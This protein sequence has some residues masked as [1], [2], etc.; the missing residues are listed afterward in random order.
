MRS[1]IRALLGLAHTVGG[2]IAFYVA[3][4]FCGLKAAIAITL[5]FLLIDGTYRLIARRPTPMIWL[6]SNA[7]ALGFGCIDLFAHTPFMLRYEGP[8][9]NG[10]VSLFFLLDAT[11][12][13]P[14]VTQYAEQS[15]A[16]V[17]KLNR[18]EWV[19]YFRV[20]TLAW[21]AAF[22]LRAGLFLW[23]GLH[24]PLDRAM[25]LRLIIG[26]S[27]IG[28]MTLASLKS[29]KIFAL[30]QRLGLFRPAPTPTASVAQ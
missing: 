20:L 11:A 23:I 17:E 5:A 10:L 22:L 29:R 25:T 24:Y 18:P 4:H 8:I 26:W 3:L 16:P 6:A 19:A 13:K 12:E 2:L 14:L 1:R 7:M 30:C 27:I 21:A 15:G 28:I 9:T